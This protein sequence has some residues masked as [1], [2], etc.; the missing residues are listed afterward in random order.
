MRGLLSSLGSLKVV[1]AIPALGV[2]FLLLILYETLS[3]VFGK[4]HDWET[5]NTVQTS[6]TQKFETLFFAV[7]DGIIYNYVRS[8]WFLNPLSNHARYASIHKATAAEKIHTRHIFYELQIRPN[9]M[10]R[11]EQLWKSDIFAYTPSQLL[12]LTNLR[13]YG[14]L[15]LFYMY[16]QE[17]YSCEPVFTCKLQSNCISAEFS[18]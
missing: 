13:L 9:L 18:I 14:I 16:N 7:Y 10:W 11:I 1:G 8:P 17:V 4:S 15:Q 2:H 3:L 6:C 12:L 5:Q